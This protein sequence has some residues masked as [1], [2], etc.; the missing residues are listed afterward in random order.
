MLGKFRKLPKATGELGLEP[1][2]WRQQRPCSDHLCL[3]VLFCSGEAY[4]GCPTHGNGKEHPVAS[5]A[6]NRELERV[7]VRMGWCPGV[8]GV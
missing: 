7:F 5:L 2:S 1:R 6:L 3:P 4:G 8:F